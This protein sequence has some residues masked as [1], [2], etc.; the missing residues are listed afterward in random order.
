MVEKIS[1]L[2]VWNTSVGNL[3]G[4]LSNWQVDEPTNWVISSEAGREMS[5]K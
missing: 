2:T 4:M 5:S 3:V 1:G